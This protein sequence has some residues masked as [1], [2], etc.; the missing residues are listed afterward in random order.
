MCSHFG[1]PEWELDLVGGSGPIC[2]ADCRHPKS[3]N[4][5]SDPSSWVPRKIARQIGEARRRPPM[6]AV[7]IASYD[8][9][10]SQLNDTPGVD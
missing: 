2:A 4:V 7:R 9:L 3:N 6:L 5:L 1:Y 8:C 10:D